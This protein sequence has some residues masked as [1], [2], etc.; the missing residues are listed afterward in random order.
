M[1]K[2]RMASITLQSAVGGA[3]EGLCFGA[4]AGFSSKKLRCFPLKLFVL[5]L[6]NCTFE[7][8]VDSLAGGQA[9]FC[10]LDVM[11]HVGFDGVALGEF[12][13]G[14]FGKDGHGLPHLIHT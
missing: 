2:R 11:V 8:L 3:L 9:A 5:L 12:G 10:C 4:I 13:V 6:N 1:W 7:E 14:G